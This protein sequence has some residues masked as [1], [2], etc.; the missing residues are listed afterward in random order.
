MR[1]T[2]EIFKHWSKKVDIS[3]KI[4][5]VSTIIVEK[6]TLKRFMYTF[7]QVCLG[8]PCQHFEVSIVNFLIEITFCNCFDWAA[9][10]K[11]QHWLESWLLSSLLS[12]LKFGK[13]SIIPLAARYL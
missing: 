4:I 3:L 13:P 8:H 2:K 10:L 9:S 12:K 11:I 6:L 7:A 1:I 5:S